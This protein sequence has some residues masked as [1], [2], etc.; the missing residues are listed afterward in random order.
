MCI[1]Q[2]T[3]AHGVIHLFEA[4][5]G[6]SETQQIG[7]KVR[8]YGRIEEAEETALTIFLVFENSEGYNGTATGTERSSYGI[9]CIRIIKSSCGKS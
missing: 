8:T 5:H 1:E 9:K 4:G 7:F 6:N 3:F 2:T